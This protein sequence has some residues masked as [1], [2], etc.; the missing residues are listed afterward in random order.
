ML[1]EGELCMAEDSDRVRELQDRI[2]ELKAEVFY[3]QIAN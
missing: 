1:T 2:A 3:R